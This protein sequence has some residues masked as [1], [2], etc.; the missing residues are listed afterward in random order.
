MKKNSGISK[1]KLNKLATESLRNVVR[2]H[3]DSVLL[4]DNGSFPS[5]FQ[6]SVLAIEELSKANWIDH[7][8]WSSETNSGYPDAESEHEWLKLLYLHPKK[9]WNFVARD[10]QFFSPNFIELIKTRKLEEKKQNS[11]YVGLKRLK[12]KIDVESRVSTPWKIKQDDAKQV[13]SMVNAELLRYCQRIES[14]EFYF[15]GAREMDEVLNYQIYS[16]LLA[17]P[18][19]S[20]LMN[21]SWV[22][23]NQKRN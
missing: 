20:G 16:Q 6:L 17:W 13:I 12:G 18:H 5:A 9:Q 15:E 14:D 1:Y 8:I 19:K 11:I 4:Y 2:L 7:Y 3:F 22:S 10:P 21:D 23:K